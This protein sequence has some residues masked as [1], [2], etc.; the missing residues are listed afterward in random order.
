MTERLHSSN[1]GMNGRKRGDEHRVRDLADGG[2]HGRRLTS[3]EHDL[4]GGESIEPV[5]GSGDE[6]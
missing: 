1:I 5:M 4:G 2:V 3:A 6:I